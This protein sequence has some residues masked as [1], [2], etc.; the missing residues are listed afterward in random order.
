MGMSIKPI[1]FQVTVPRTA[2]ASKM[3]SD[4][5]Q[6]SVIA[7]QQAASSVKDKVDKDLRQVE[8]KNT[9]QNIEI[10]EKNREEKNRRDNRKGKKG[11]RDEGDSSKNTTGEPRASRIDIRL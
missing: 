7:H 3:S 2:D 6:R 4:E 1:D 10:K 8:Q 9:A 5:N 11:M